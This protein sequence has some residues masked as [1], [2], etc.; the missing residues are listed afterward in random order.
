MFCTDAHLSW[1]K[2]KMYVP[3]VK[4]IYKIKYKGLKDIHFKIYLRNWYTVCSYC[5]E[6]KVT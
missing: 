2:E 1:F 5:A 6:R 3:V 4:D